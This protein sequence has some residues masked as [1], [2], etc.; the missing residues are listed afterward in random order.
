MWA[1]PSSKCRNDA[2]RPVSRSGLAT[3]RLW[4]MRPYGRQGYTKCL[5]TFHSVYTVAHGRRPRS[6]I[7]RPSASLYDE[8]GRGV[9]A[10][11]LRIL[12]DP[13]QAQDVMQD[14]FLKLWR[15]PEKFDARR[16]Q[17]GPV[18]QADGAA[19]ARWTSGARAR[20]P[21]GPPTA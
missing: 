12:G 10:A 11:A 16:G 14:V 7:P 13:A 3:P 19:R 2:S 6:V 15:K 9:Y 5:T 17:L 18:P 21:A 4:R 8:H 20:P 1:P